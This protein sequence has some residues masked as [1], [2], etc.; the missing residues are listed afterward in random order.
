[1]LDLLGTLRFLEDHQEYLHDSS[2]MGIRM[3]AVPLDRIS[4]H[5]KPEEKISQLMQTKE[6]DFLQR[7]VVDLTR[8]LS[9]ESGV[10]IAYFGVTGS[11]L[12]DIHQK[13]SDIDLVIYGLRNSQLVKET[14]IRIYDEQGS[15][16]RRFDERKA[17]KWCMNK[18]KMYPLTYEEA[19]AIFRRKWGR[20]LFRRTMF[21][22]HPVKLEEEVSERYGDRIFKAEGMGKM[23][24]IVSD[25]SE[26][27]FLPSIY[28]VED[29]KIL[30]GEK[31]G[32]IC[33]VASYEGLYG[34]V[35]EEGGRIM[36]YGKLE[37]VI[38][39]RSGRE[40]HRVLV[41]SKEAEGKDYI[42]PVYLP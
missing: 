7:K 1:M 2:V 37:R 10:P 29:V 11:V 31:I 40:Y 27:D 9:D 42:K 36:V 25:A 32:D 30:E 41:G 16:I 33:E 28:K 15:P 14:L 12:L 4:A 22:I 18:A 6:L 21:S 17:R 19:R 26:A 38:D 34:G 24:A 39:K 8:I 3:S 13:F 23:E 20:G 5:L 35:A